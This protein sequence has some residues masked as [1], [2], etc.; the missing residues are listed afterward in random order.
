MAFC[1]AAGCLILAGVAGALAGGDVEFA[2]RHEHLRKGC[3]GTIKVTE[4]GIAFSGPKKHAWMWKYQD[5]QELKAAPGSLY[6]LTY[7][8]SKLRLGADRAFEF[9]GAVPPELFSLWSARLDQRFVAATARGGLEGWSVPVKHLRR[10][11]GSEGLLT[12]GPERIEYATEA[13]E[14]AR[15]WRYRDIEN[16]SSSGPFQLTIVTFERARSH[17]G[18]RKG[19]NFQLKQSLDEA[20]FNQLWLDIEVKNGRI[21]K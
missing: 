17:Y 2:A 9:T 11:S 16:I 19:F 15:T 21:Q 12:F 14:D 5:I 8:D 4:D 10:V 13:K 6:V 7:R 3:A 20:R 18:D 1:K